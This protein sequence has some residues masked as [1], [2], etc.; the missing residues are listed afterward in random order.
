MIN[1]ITVDKEFQ[2]NRFLY[3]EIRNS[4]N[5][6]R[7]RM[8]G[9]SLIFNSYS[10]KHETTG[11]TNWRKETRDAGSKEFLSAA[12]VDAEDPKGRSDAPN[13]VKG[14]ECKLTSPIQG[15]EQTTKCRHQLVAAVLATVEAHIAATPDAVNAVCAIWFR[16]NILKLDLHMSI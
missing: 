13:L 8:I 7:M 9:E 3:T 6:T 5:D 14:N 2:N 10:T 12:H 16:Q 11:F 1:V 4:F 15:D